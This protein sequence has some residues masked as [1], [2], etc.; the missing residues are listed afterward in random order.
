L[1]NQCY[2][3][4]QKNKTIELISNFV[5]QFGRG[6]GQPII[7][8]QVFKKNQKLV[9]S[10]AKVAGRWHGWAGGRAASTFHNNL[11]TAVPIDFISRRHIA[12]G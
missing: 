10:L 1:E 7:F 11:T 8:N 5:R 6:S 2:S 12:V 4:G 9:H 3:T